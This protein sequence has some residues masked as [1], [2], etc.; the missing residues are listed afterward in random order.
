MLCTQA[1]TGGRV[2]LPSI[3]S[4]L[5]ENNIASVMVEGGVRVIESLM[6]AR[7]IDYVVVTIAPHFVGGEPDVRVQTALLA[8]PRI[9]RFEHANIG[10]DLVLWGKPVWP[11]Q[12]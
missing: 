9:E 5:A 8:G 1:T 11:A 10:G 7:L 4:R 12:G 6:A 2:D 3:L